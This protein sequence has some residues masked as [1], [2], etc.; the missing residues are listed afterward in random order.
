MQA[1]THT[2]VLQ[3]QLGHSRPATTAIYTH[4]SDEPLYQVAETMDRYLSGH[5]GTEART[6]HA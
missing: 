4:V 1:G 5:A 3:E 6:H 2:R